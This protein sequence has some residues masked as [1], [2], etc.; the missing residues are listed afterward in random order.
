MSKPNEEGSINL[1][2]WPNDIYTEHNFYN[3]MTGQISFF[4]YNKKPFLIQNTEKE[5]LLH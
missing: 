4:F 3:F 2:Q 5:Q 1:G